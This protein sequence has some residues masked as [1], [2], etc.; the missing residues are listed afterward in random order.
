MENKYLEKI[1]TWVEPE[2]SNVYL[3]KV[4]GWISNAIGK[5]KTLPHG[6]GAA[7]STFNAFDQMVGSGMRTVQKATKSKLPTDLVGVGAKKEFLSKVR[8][9]PMA[10]NRNALNGAPKTSGT[11]PQGFKDGMKRNR[12]AMFTDLRERMGMVKDPAKT[13]ISRTGNAITS[14][15]TGYQDPGIKFNPDAK[16][17]YL[18][19]SISSVQKNQAANHRIGTARAK[20]AIG[21]A[22]VA[23]VGALGYHMANKNSQ[24]QYQDYGTMPY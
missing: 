15:T 20:L 24:P 22:G 19:K 7:G 6:G 14:R 10:G 5:I 3:E 11:L 17:K 9:D 2:Q 16:N 1:A 23:G 12:K 21:A 8:T 13:S 18:S 4:A